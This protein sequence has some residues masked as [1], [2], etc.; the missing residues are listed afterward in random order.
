MLGVLLNAELSHGTEDDALM[1]G[2]MSGEVIE[3]GVHAAG[4][5]VVGV[6]DDVVARGLEDLASTIGRDVGG[7]GIVDLVG[8]DAEE[9]TDGDGGLGIFEIVVAAEVGIDEVGS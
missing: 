2:C 6:D 1:V 5:G 7:D 9:E 4:V 8:L 3:G